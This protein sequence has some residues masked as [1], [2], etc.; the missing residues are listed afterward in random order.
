MTLE[1]CIESVESAIAAAEGGADRVELCANL[2]EGGTTPSLGTV[3]RTR[4]SAQI[5]LSVMVRPRGGDFFYSPEEFEVMREDVRILREEGVD[6][7]VIGLLLPDGR[8]DQERTAEL[9]ELARPCQVTFH[10]AFDMTRDPQEA[11]TTLVELGVNRILTSGQEESVLEGLPLI[12]E[13]VRKAG[14]RISVM[15]G[16]GVTLKNAAHIARE[17]GAKEIH[18]AATRPFESGMHFRNDRVFMGT[19][20]RSAEYQ[21][22]L[23]TPDAVRA[24]KSAV[25]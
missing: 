14:E 15:P 12:K 1:M 9:I 16:C 18:V 24:F 21:R 11:L 13:L 6:G 2:L 23:T 25:G 5:A 17:T 20:L 22:F 7:V 19:A 8:I 3:R 4:H 10:R